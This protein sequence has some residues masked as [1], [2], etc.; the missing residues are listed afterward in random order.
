[1][2]RDKTVLQVHVGEIGT[3]SQIKLG[4]RT[5][6]GQQTKELGHTKLFIVVIAWSRGTRCTA[7]AAL[8]VAAC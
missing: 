4:T 7:G 6:C 2:K 3:R 1:M 8:V 5:V